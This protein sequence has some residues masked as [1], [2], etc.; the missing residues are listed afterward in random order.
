MN[1]VSIYPARHFVTPKERLEAA[2]LN[3][4]QELEGRL[5]ELEKPE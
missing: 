3:I 5:I 2:C 4:R 1:G